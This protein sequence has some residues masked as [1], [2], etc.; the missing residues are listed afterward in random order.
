LEAPSLLSI[1][2]Y[3]QW[4]LAKCLHTESEALTKIHRFKAVLSNY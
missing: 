1:T 4:F 3:C 2:I